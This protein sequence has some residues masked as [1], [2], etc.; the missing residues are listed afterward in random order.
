MTQTAG[1]RCLEN[2]CAKLVRPHG[3]VPETWR[4]STKNLTVH[5]SCWILPAEK[6]WFSAA[7]LDRESMVASLQ[8]KTSRQR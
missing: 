4:A 5:G 1:C 8:P 6:D 2:R 3:V 7:C